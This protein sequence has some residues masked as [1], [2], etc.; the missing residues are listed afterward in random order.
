MVSRVLRGPR[1]AQGCQDQQAPPELWVLRAPQD[2]QDRWV[3]L[4]NQESL[5][6]MGCLGKKEH[7]DYLGS[8]A[9]LDLQAW[10]A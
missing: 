7:M 10:A 1:G 5:E 8:R 2:C 6:E 9:L 4:V 3:K